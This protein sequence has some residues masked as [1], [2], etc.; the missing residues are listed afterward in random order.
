MTQIRWL[1]KG[2]QLTNCP[3]RRESGPV[4]NCTMFLIIAKMK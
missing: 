3:R 2:N 4:A 1:R